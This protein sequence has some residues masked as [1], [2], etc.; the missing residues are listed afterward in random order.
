M[1]SIKILEGSDVITEDVWCRPLEFLYESRASDAVFSRSTYSGRPINNM[2]WVPIQYA[3]GSCW[4]GKTVAEF[5]G[6]EC[7]CEFAIGDIPDEHKLDVR[8]HMVLP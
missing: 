6:N 5:Q 8:E 7:S 1:K 2:K 4:L 3:L